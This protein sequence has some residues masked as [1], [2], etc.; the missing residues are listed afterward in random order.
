MV[1]C[2]SKRCW[3]INAF[4]WL[5]NLTVTITSL[6]SSL[7]IFIV[8]ISVAVYPKYTPFCVP[9]LYQTVTK[10]MQHSTT[11]VVLFIWLL[12]RRVLIILSYYFI[13]ITCWLVV[14]R[15]ILT[16]SCKITAYWF[17]NFSVTITT[18]TWVYQVIQFLFMRDR[19]TGDVYLIK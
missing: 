13:T 8:I 5:L 6:L 10:E 11:I 9:Y 17:I 19:I 1:D 14:I 3:S 4:I 16:W 7:V 2:H 12:A 15:L 18:K